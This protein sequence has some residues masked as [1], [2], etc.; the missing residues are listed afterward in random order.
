MSNAEPKFQT[1][2]TRRLRAG[3][4]SE[5]DAGTLTHV[6]EFGCSVVSV[7]PSGAGLGYTVGVY[8]TAGKPEVITTGLG[9]NTALTLL[10]QAADRL[11]AGVD[12]TQG[13]YRDM[14]GEVECEF[15]TVDPKWVKHLMGL[16]LWYYDGEEF[17]VLQAIYPDLEIAFLKTT[18]SM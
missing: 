16:A 13:R 6:E 4:L 18:A 10:N 3:Q 2:R 9:D 1:D 14:L 12:L 15:R 7:K 17:P 8:D 5:A 11:R